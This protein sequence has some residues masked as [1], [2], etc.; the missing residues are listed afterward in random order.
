MQ[1][2][3]SLV[4]LTI[5]CMQSAQAGFSCSEDGMG[6]W[7]GTATIVNKLSR[8]IIVGEDRLAPGE[9]LIVQLHNLCCHRSDEQGQAMTISCD[10][11]R[12][13]CSLCWQLNW[14][15]DKR[16]QILITTTTSDENNEIVSYVFVGSLNAKQATHTLVVQ[17]EQYDPTDDPSTVLNFDIYLEKKSGC[18]IL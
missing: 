2:F 14:Q 8:E 9:S 17:E 1:F 15:L 12:I 18:S 7:S 4:M 6:R 11:G 5:L 16:W 13:A 10:D 3:Y